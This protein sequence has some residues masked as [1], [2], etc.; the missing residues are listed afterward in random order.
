MV[1]VV[2]IF[3]WSYVSGIYISRSFPGIIT[4]SLPLTGGSTVSVLML[5]HSRALCLSP[6]SLEYNQISDEGGRAF[7][8][9]LRVNSSLTTLG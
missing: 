9:A 1:L 6:H 7:A 3:S 5:H 4:A 2:E 8:A